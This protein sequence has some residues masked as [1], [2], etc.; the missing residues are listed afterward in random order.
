MLTFALAGAA[1][2]LAAQ[3]SLPDVSVTRT[4][5]AIVETMPGTNFTASYRIRNSGT[6]AVKLLAALNAPPGWMLVL[7]SEPFTIAAGSTDLSL[8]SVAVPARASAGRY[9]IALKFERDGPGGRSI[10]VDSIVVEI[11]EH[12]AVDLK[13]VSRPSYVIAG[14][15]YA[16]SLALSNRGNS[17]A[18]F[19][20]SAAASSGTPTRYEKGDII[21]DAGASKLVAV[22]VDTRKDADRA[23][24]DILE[25]R[26]SNVADT[27]IHAD[28]S[29]TVTIVLP[30][31][32]EIPRTPVPSRITVRSFPR[33]SGVSPYEIAGGGRLREGSPE[34]LEFLFRGS[35]GAFSSFGDRDEYRVQ[36]SS[37]H[38]SVRTGDQL[39]S[40]SQLLSGGQMGFGGGLDV[41]GDRFAAGAYSTRF[42]FQPGKLSE[43]GGYA[44]GHFGAGSVTSQFALNAVTRPNGPFAGNLIGSTARIN[45]GENAHIDL[46]VAR[47]VSSGMSGSALSA[48]IV[49]TAPFHYD[50]GHIGANA[51]F[52]G[53]PRG[54]SQSYASLSGN[55]VGDLELTASANS[56][57]HSF[58][59]DS[60]FSSERSLNTN[61]AA[62][63]RG[64]T[65]E[66]VTTARTE[67]NQGEASSFSERGF[68]LRTSAN[69]SIFS[70]WSA[71]ERGTGRDSTGGGKDYGE[72]SGGGT[73]ATQWLRLS[74]YSD[75]Y[76][77]KSINRGPVALLNFGGD[78]AAVL[79]FGMTL[80]VNAFRTAPRDS[81]AVPTL[82]LDSRLVKTLDNGASLGFRIRH[83]TR[84][85][86]SGPAANIGYLEYSLP[87]GLRLARA[88]AGGRAVGRI[89]DRESGRGIANTL[90]RVG[91]QAALT[92]RSGAVYF[93]GLPT[94]EYRASIAQDVAAAST[95]VVGNPNVKIDSTGEGRVRT[96]RLAVDLPGAIHARVR[97]MALAKTGVGEAPDSLID[98]GPVEGVTVAFVDGADTVY[99]ITDEK[100]EV[101]AA[102]LP[103]GTWTVAVADDAPPMQR[104]SPAQQSVTVSRG[105]AASVSF[106]LVPTRRRIKIIEDE[107]VPLT[108][109][110]RKR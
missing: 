91:P 2:R 102:E 39:F 98:A 51:L 85:S 59:R 83:T 96:F 69:T 22:N 87:F 27:S 45:P 58:R 75:Y 16:L 89:V 47:S 37:T 76:N 97:Q 56:G 40:L 14:N 105:A 53:P 93:N 24:E 19:R 86:P 110:P 61:L 88:N 29:T 31:G 43:T 9:P 36:L 70:V 34:K 55:P 15:S 28:V 20:I 73:L 23:I 38:Y 65:L 4:S 95:V 107:K 101:S 33:N 11:E 106:S 52:A 84:L 8:V 41:A 18:A 21:L 71:L 90:V 79:P 42:R 100:G 81:I 68:I 12:R 26:A 104:Y 99:R 1:P 7:G 94:G 44:G 66:H 48:R 72:Y 80:T 30:A 49:G 13:L 103:P 63:W 78:L 57:S 54:T 17:P 10:S 67:R 62:A 74:A 64:L 82:Q 46:E 77:G 92:D 35:P 6:N 5:A 109:P 25:I 32:S 50:F 108:P 60:I 3:A